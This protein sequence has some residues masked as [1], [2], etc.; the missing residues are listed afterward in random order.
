MDAES[1]Q[2]VGFGSIFDNK[3]NLNTDSESV[4]LD[5]S[6]PEYAASFSNYT[7]CRINPLIQVDRFFFI[8]LLNLIINLIGS[9]TTTLFKVSS[10]LLEAAR[11]PCKYKLSTSLSKLLYFSFLGIRT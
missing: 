11:T 1:H 8:Y 3:I 7:D 6:K 5:Y 9:H 4:L 2:D 10:S